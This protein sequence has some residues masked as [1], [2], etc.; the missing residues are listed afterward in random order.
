M[1]IAILGAM[2]EEV[3]PLLE[4]LKEYQTVEYANNTYYLAKYKNHELII[5]YSKIGKVNST[6][7]A[8]IMIE[9]FKAELLL[10]TGVAGAF[11]P[12]LE[13]G[14]LIYAT[15]LAQYDL[16]ITAFGHPLGYVPG[17]EIFIKTDDKLNNLA[18]EVAKELGVKLQS[19]I[20]AT[21]DEFIC[22]E[23]KKAKIR[24]IFNADACEMEGASVALVCDALKIPCLILR[25]MS[26]KAGEKAEFDFDEFVEK[27]AKI[28]ANFVLKIC[29]KL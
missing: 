28:S 7:S 27:S 12:S 11:N 5:A 6:L 24:E 18:I 20:I 19:G 4:T 22:D 2:P 25:S 17:N 26:D 23:S 9:K 29:E 15:K 8:A 21:G 10:F 13:I 14:D 16:D 1:K 3:T